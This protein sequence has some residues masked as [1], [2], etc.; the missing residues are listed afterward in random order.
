VV[1]DWQPDAPLDAIDQEGPGAG[2]CD[3][4][5]PSVCIP[6]IEVTGD[7]DCKQVDFR[8]FDVIPPDPH[9]FDLDYDGVGCESD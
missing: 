3:P 7:L 9:Q 1:D 4:S 8:R 5:Y 6:P 2:N